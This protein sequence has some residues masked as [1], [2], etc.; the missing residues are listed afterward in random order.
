M[1]DTSAAPR[2]EHADVELTEFLH[3]VQG[4]CRDSF[5]RLY[6]ATSPRL[7]AVVMSLSRSES[8]AEEILQDVYVMVWTRCAQFD[9]NKGKAIHWLAGIARN[10]ATSSLL[11]QS[12]RS[13][14]VSR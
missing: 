14:R 8:E 5:A 7:F 10:A 13:T 11:R 6:S 9:A 12:C 3:A 2:H 4:G 1:R